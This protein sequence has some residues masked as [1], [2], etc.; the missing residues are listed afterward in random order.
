MK[1]VIKMR[2]LILILWLC[3]A[4]GL[5]LA[6]PNMEELVRDKGQISVPDGYSSSTAAKMVKEMKGDASGSSNEQSAVLVFHNEKG[7]NASD[8]EEIKR[9]VGQLKDGEAKYG[10]TEVITHLDT[11]DLEEQM[12]AKDGKTVLVL[13]SASMEG[14]TP[15]EA[16][17]AL[18][19]ALEGVSVEHY[20]T[21]DWLIGED[22]IQSSQEGLKKTEYITVIFILAILFIVFRSA[23]APFIPLLTV[24]LSYLVAQS[25]VGFLVEWV[26]FPLSNFTQIFMVAIMFGIG[27][28]YCILLISRFKEELAQSED[29]TAAI[30]NTYRTAGK[31]VFFSGLAVLVGFAS[32]GLSTFSLYRS[33]VAV[34]V[35]VAVLLIALVTLVPFF[36]ATMGK[37]IFWPSK[38]TLEH[39]PSR[40][41]GAVGNFSLKRPVWALVI[42]AVVLV[43]FL[44]AYQGATSYNSLEEIGDKYNSVKAFN[45]ITESFGP[46]DSMPS[47]IVVK[48]DQPLDT[49]EGMAAV[50]RVTRELDEVD[51]V[52][53]VRS[54]TRPS[55]DPL[56][57]L[58]VAEQ[59]KQLGD[60][61][62][63]GG[64]ALGQINQGLTDA[65]TALKDNQPKLNE[66]V[67]GAGQLVAGTNELKNGVVQLGDGLK[68]IEKGLVD[69][70]MGAEQI[71]AGLKQAKESADR[72]KAGSD[73]LLANY[74]AMHGGFGEMAKGYA[75]IQQN[76]SGLTAGIAG[77]GQGLDGLAQKYPELIND[78]D[79]KNLRSSV[80]GLESGA[81]GLG[82][83]LAQLN[84]QLGG[85]LDGFKQVNDGYA[86]AIEG[87][88]A[89]SAGLGELS[90]ALV[91]LQAGLD[92][93]AGGQSQIV[94]KVPAVTG[95]FD[96][97]AN[98][99]KELQK[100]YADMNGQL[101]QLT[102]GLTQ[103]ADGLAQ[104]TDGL[105]EANGYLSDLSAG[106]DKQLTGWYLPQEALDNEDFQKALDAYMSE[107]RKIA[108]FDVVFAGNP[109]E[110]DTLERM[111]DL[112]AAVERAL[113]D[114]DYAGAAFAVEGV[115]S[116]NNDLRNIS[117]E[118]YSRTVML[119][120]IGIGLILVLM[121]RSI[122]MPI[123]IILSLL[124][125]YYSSLAIA[126]V[127]FVRIL[128]YT[129]ISWA[130]PFFGFVML[131]ALGVDYSIFL[132][133]RFKEYRHL[134][135]RE[136]I[137]LAMKNMGSVIISA[138]VIL[139]GTFAAMLPSGVMSL[140]QIATILLCG[141]FLYALLML[142]LFIPVMVRTFD[143][144]NWWPF[145]GEPKRKEEAKP[146]AKTVEA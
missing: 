10:I 107:D 140:L 5:F 46:G 76:V 65:S 125:T 26:N 105:E 48:V 7:I 142:P 68:Q 97:I 118:D 135:P 28:D 95:G 99:Q 83:G 91:G 1:T 89:L 144:A 123:Y 62:D 115:S 35:G 37:A 53:T 82:D 133:D 94:S 24:G 32:I 143:K 16:R 3:A 120:L 96:Q 104:V 121:F 111:D 139:G 85:A 14:R 78:Q 108:S 124:I 126:E 56:E 47:K 40:L 117:A 20:Y 74:Q 71:S 131:M 146:A 61:L 66:A 113:K 36:M 4:V 50:E 114:T 145:M 60:G 100:G 45:V 64:D 43:P 129:G 41:W 101:G 13:V 84:Q 6:A 70:S 54:A 11:K 136:G 69:G 92:Q 141:L 138:A 8:L 2:W 9:G 137:L 23:V 128:G 102:D 81:K 63:Q 52:K 33:A 19:E 49:P 110:I 130:V 112:T 31:T 67:Q 119:M 39:K 34:G 44:A 103:S 116:I 134:P 38:G 88:K 90:S 87:Q 21:G 57:D 109:Y 86:Q 93:L 127:I 132:M 27:T 18:Y 98:G 58:Q 51:G 73:A 25:V 77:V 122:V 12:V 59:V 30:L 80:T 72:L 15:A 106:P 22:V 79:F 55:G 42:L 17:D 29:R 75:S